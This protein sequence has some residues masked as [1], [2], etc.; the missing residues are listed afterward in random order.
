MDEVNSL[1]KD[2]GDSEDEDEGSPSRLVTHDPTQSA[3][4]LVETRR[5]SMH[6]HQSTEDG[7]EDDSDDASN[8]DENTPALARKRRVSFGRRRTIGATGNGAVTD[9]TASAELTRSRRQSTVA[10]DDYAEQAALYSSDIMLKRRVVALYVQLCELKSYIQLNKTGFRK[11]LKKFDKICNRSLRQK[12]MEKVVESAPPFVPEATKA[13]EDNVSK[14]EHAYANLVTKGDIDIARRDLRSHLREHVVWERNTVWR[15]MI[16]MER[17]A[18]A[19][20]LGRALLGGDIATGAARL[21][22]DEENAIPTKEI[23]TPI[24]RFKLPTWLVSTSLLNL[25]IIL[26]VFTALLVLPIMESPEQQNCLAILVFASMMWA[27]EVRC[28]MK[29]P[30]FSF[31]CLYV[32]LFCHLQPSSNN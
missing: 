1:L 16:G 22:G 8:D 26:A 28:L 15:D 21:Q 5:H 11:V 29:P 20:S 9:M 32:F 18:E 7:G 2:I 6:S 30:F 24:G 27:T 14:M 17:R 4:A 23:A 13:V 12:Y 19:A 10:F 31:L 3:S 25:V